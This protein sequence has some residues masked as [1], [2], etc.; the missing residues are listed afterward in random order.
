MVEAVIVSALENIKEFNNRVFPLDA[1]EKTPAPYCAYFQSSGSEFTAF[2]GGC[3]LF[4]AQYEINIVH[5]SYKGMKALIEAAL[6]LLNGI[7]GKDGV[8]A[9][10]IEES[11]PER[12]EDETILYWKTLYLKIFYR[13]G[14]TK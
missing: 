9:V 6:L 13:G 2:E 7:E 1:P 3:G 10:F 4:E 5:K 12:F 8:E 11:T 14:I